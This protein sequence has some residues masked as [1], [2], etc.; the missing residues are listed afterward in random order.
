MKNSRSSSTSNLKPDNKSETYKFD[1][2]RLK[3]S[4]SSPTI[5]ALSGMSREEKRAFILSH[6]K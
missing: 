5:L 2:N 3:E 6:S 1:F 4:M